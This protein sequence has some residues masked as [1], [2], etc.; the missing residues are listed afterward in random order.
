MVKSFRIP[1]RRYVKR[2]RFER[3]RRSGYLRSFL[4]GVADNLAETAAGVTVTITGSA[5]AA[6]AALF[7]NSQPRNLDEVIIAGQTYRFV[8]A[9]VQAG[10]V[11]LDAD[12]AAAQ[13]L[14]LTGNVAEGDTVTVGGKTYTFQAELT[15]VNGNVHIGAN[16]SD[17]LDNLID[18][19]NLG[20]GAGTDYA[21]ATT[22]NANVS[23]LA[24]D[25]DTMIATAKVAG[26]AGNEIA[27]LIDTGEFATA[28]WS[29]LA[30]DN[31]VE[32]ETVTIGN[33]VY[34]FKD[35][36]DTTANE[37][38]VGSDAAESL[39]NLMA[40]INLTGEGGEYGSE[41]TAHTQVD[42]LSI[43]GTTTLSL[44]L[45]AKAVGTAGNSYAS[46]DTSTDGSF[47]GATFAGG[48]AS[49]GSWGDD[50]LAGG[51]DADIDDTLQNLADAVNGEDGGGESGTTYH[52]DT[53]AHDTVTAG[54]P[55]TGELE[56]EAQT[57]GVAGNAFKVDAVLF[58][59]ES[60]WSAPYFTGGIG[61][62]VFG[63]TDHGY[64]VGSGPFILTAATT[65]PAGY[66]AGTLLYVRTVL[67]DDTFEV[68]TKP[69]G[70]VASFDDDGTGTLTLTPA[71][72][73][74][75]MHALLKK[76]HPKVLA[77]ADDVDDL[78]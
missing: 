70:P 29:M 38:L 33:K 1:N 7:L 61:I 25:N 72:T 12:G 62:T 49:S 34:T 23:A 40:A 26:A 75:A 68:T 51:T 77:E 42:A 48:V 11:L 46:E 53:V 32:D 36:V 78:V 69:G 54:T 8:T 59:D 14:T 45:R 57:E 18:A 35:V 21:A 64:V 27:S 4:Q 39:A 43:T 41:T 74:E 47:V 24:G 58:D 15:N 65:L 66:V 30:A 73:E 50:T 5:V 10:D 60:G 17:S 3:L 22:I 52:E 76:H 31:A 9:L 67:G 71:E 20:A 44:N 19:I 2:G 37:V 16:A 28:A 63:A 56:F 55:D 6:S 13:T